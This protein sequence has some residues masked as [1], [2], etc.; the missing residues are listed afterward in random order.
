MKAIKQQQFKERDF[1]SNINN[2]KVWIESI[3]ELDLK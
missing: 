2:W 1:Y 3:A